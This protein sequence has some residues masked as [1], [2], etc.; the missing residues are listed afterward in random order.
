VKTILEHVW[1]VFTH[2]RAYKGAFKIPE[3]WEREMAALATIL[4]DADI[5]FAKIEGGLK[6]YSTSYDAYM[7]EEQM[8]E[9]IKK[10]S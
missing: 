1:G 2:D 10:W 4:E 7:T 8:R 5:S 3:K 9:E 6:R